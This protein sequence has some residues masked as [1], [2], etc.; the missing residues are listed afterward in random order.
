MRRFNNFLS[1]LDVRK[2][3]SGRWQLLAPFEFHLGSPDGVESV[4]VPAGFVTDFASIP[5]PLWSI[6][7]PDGDYGKAAVCHDYLYL[8]RVVLILDSPS[9]LVTRVE[10]DQIFL[11][12]MQVLSIGWFTRNTLYRGVRVTGRRT[13]NR[14]R[15]QERESTGGS[16]R[17]QARG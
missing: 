7:P 16:G 12:G 17:Q 3:D 2:L 6:W 11:A 14:Y 9:R 13:W 15:E 1:P 4:S 10:A 5:R 8:R